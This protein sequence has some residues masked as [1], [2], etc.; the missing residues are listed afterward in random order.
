MPSGYVPKEIDTENGVARKMEANTDENL[1][2]DVT[3]WQPK[4]GLEG[5]SF[6]TRGACSA[7]NSLSVALGSGVLGA[8]R[9]PSVRSA[10]DFFQWELCGGLPCVL[11]SAHI[12]L[13]SLTGP[14]WPG[15][16]TRKQV[17]KGQPRGTTAT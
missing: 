9:G 10:H 3:S 7:H 16:V 15:V 11:D 2:P 5:G 4:S 17:L 13:P 6:R 14:S 12:Y 8:S 1:P